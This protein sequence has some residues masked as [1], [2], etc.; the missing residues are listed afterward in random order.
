M[1]FISYSAICGHNLK[2]RIYKRFKSND[3]RF[4]IIFNNFFQKTI[5][6]MKQ[7]VDLEKFY[8][9]HFKF[10]FSIIGEIWKAQLV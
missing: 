9:C 2:N 1:S 8:I 6:P 4:S 5:I 10:Q 7:L 3:A